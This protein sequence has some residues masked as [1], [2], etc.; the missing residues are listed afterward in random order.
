VAAGLGSYGQ[1]LSDRPARDITVAGFVA[2][3]PMSMLGLGI[4]LLVSSST[5]SFG[6][7]GLVAGT[8]TLTQAVAAPLWGRLIDRVGQ[9]FGLL[10]AALV[11]NVS[12]VL[13]ITTVMA[14][15][16]L[17]MTVLTAAG[18]GAGFSSAGAAVRARWVHRL[19]DGRLLQTAFAMEAVVDE[20]VFIVGP[21]VVTAL[22]TAVHP[23]A[24]LAA[25]VALGLAGAF[26]LASQRGTQ[27]P[28][29][30]RGTGR[31][32]TGRLSPAAL[33]PVVVA[34]AS[35]GALFGGMELA[36]VA[37]ATHAGIVKLTGLLI[38]AWAT[39]SLVSGLLTGA[40]HWRTP[41]ARRFRIGAAAL[42]V[43]LLPLLFV[44]HPAL[45]AVVLVL[46]GVTIAP[47]LV[48]S[49]A[50]TQQSVAPHRLTEA[51]GW[52]TTGLAA[53]IAG[54]AAVMGQIVDTWGARAGFGGVVVSGLVLAAAA[55]TVRPAR[56]AAP[57]GDRATAATSPSS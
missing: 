2:R 56:A 33:V 41:P 6:I 13:L 17:W 53:G 1:V 19:G 42:A 40:V 51:L 47:T 57:A 4:V 39:G 10:C 24:G 11:C 14:G 18:T 5:G 16:P 12:L 8:V 48:A 7:A 54:G 23:A 32:D 29:R 30:R 9:A 36:V 46:S 55:A 45:L 34:C 15:L 22:A 37:F 31:A 3:L 21:V 43:S 52:T 50:V 35:L 25:C 49:V 26:W 38:M 28:A 20:L 44:S 27:P